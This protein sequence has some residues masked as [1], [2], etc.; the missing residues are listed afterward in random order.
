M[1]CSRNILNSHM[2]I[3]ISSKFCSI[4]GGVLVLST[5]RASPLR[6]A[7]PESMPRAST[8]WQES[9]SARH[10]YC[11]GE[12]QAQLRTHGRYN[13]DTHSLALQCSTDLTEKHRACTLFINP[14]N[15][16]PAIFDTVALGANTV[17]TIE[18][19]LQMQLPH[20]WRFIFQGKRGKTIDRMAH[21][22]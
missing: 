9:R 2:R 10:C 20:C 11:G 16:N 7:S 22:S 3:W 4:V 13:N 18:V 14:E 21:Q 6:N 1:V 5:R 15:P 17:S 12:V 8:L 19:T